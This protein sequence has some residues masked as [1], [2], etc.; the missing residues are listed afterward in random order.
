MEGV[1][2]VSKEVGAGPIGKME[3]GDF[4]GIDSIGTKDILK[5]FK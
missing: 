3:T 1:G 4:S 2:R 5:S